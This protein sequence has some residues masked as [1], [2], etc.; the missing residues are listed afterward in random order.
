[1]VEGF[2][3]WLFN[4]I[5]WGSIVGLILLLTETASRGFLADNL[6][7][8]RAAIGVVVVA[9]LALWPRF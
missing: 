3:G 4:F 6:D 9:V 2:S 1:M 7:G 5:L 8:I